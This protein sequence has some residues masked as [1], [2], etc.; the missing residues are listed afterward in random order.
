VIAHRREQRG[1]GID[2]GARKRFEEH[3][4]QDLD[5]AGNT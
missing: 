1:K 3:L 4:A 2:V 5:M